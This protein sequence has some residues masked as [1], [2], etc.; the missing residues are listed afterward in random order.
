MVP[1]CGMFPPTQ[2]STLRVLPKLVKQ[3]SYSVLSERAH[4]LLAQSHLR[5]SSTSN[6]DIQEEG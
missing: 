1:I 3:E 5:N 6:S 4:K 2:H